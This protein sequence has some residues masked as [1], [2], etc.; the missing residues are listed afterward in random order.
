MKR[1]LQV[2][3]DDVGNG[4]TDTYVNKLV[5]TEMREGKE[6]WEER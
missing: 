6:G 3:D 1:G 4:K 2:K 5:S